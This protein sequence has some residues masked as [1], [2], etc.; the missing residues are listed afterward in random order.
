MV[1][2]MISAYIYIYIYIH[3]H[4]HKSIISVLILDQQSLQ[5]GFSIGGNVLEKRALGFWGNEKRKRSGTKIHVSVYSA[6]V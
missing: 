5:N 2:I 4:I 1:K 3:I 6:R